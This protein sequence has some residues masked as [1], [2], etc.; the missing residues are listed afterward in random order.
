MSIK[1]PWNI[2]KGVPLAQKLMPQ[3][4]AAHMIRVREGREAGRPVAG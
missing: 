2:R 4:L 1:T 3:T